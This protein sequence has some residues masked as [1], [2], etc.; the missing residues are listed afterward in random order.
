MSAALLHQSPV[1][2]GNIVLSCYCSHH[3]EFSNSSHH[4]NLSG[5]KG[6][7]L[8]RSKVGDTEAKG[9]EHACYTV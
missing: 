4:S 9:D 6:K 7:R 1:L 5:S 8:R 2:Y 3:S